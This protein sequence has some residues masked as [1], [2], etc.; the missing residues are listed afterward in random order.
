MLSIKN[1]NAL[2]ALARKPMINGKI[3]PEFGLVNE[4]LNALIEQIMLEE[5]NQFLTH[6]DLSN[7]VF[8]DE[9]KS[10]VPCKG[11]IRP[12]V[13]LAFQG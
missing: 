8:V 5:R 12:L 7:R 9:P 4:P 11:F 13:R 1:Q 6:S 10:S 3:N 2:K